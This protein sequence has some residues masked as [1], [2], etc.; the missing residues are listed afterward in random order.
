MLPEIVLL[1]IVN[2]PPAAKRWSDSIN[3]NG[4]HRAPRYYQRSCC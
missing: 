1:V 2:M 3:V 4:R